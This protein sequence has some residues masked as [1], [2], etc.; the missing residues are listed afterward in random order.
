MLACDASPFGVAAVLSHQF[1]DGSERPITYASKS[2]SAAEKNYSHLDKEALAI[3]F[4]VKRFHNY[5]YGR[6]FHITN[7]CYPFWD[8]K[9]V[10]HH[11]LPLTCNVGP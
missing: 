1:P 9:V 2:L 5:I 8:P 7:R 11:L 10:F 6:R 3:V 4:G